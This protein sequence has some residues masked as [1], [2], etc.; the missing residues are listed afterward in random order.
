MAEPISI[1]I[2]GAGLAGLATGISLALET[3]DRPVD[4]RPKITILEAL[5]SLAPVGAGLQLTPNATR[6][7]ARWG[8]LQKIEA[9]C[10][11]PRRLVVHR[12][13]DGEVLACDERFSERVRGRYDGNPFIDVHRGDLQGLL[14]ERAKGLGVGVEWAERVKEMDFDRTEASGV[15]VLA[16]SGR[17]FEADLLVGAD[18]IW[19]RCREAL[20]MQSDPPL[21][22]GDLA[23]R[24]VLTT[25]ALGEDEELRRWVQRP[26]CHFWI[27][28]NSHVVG[29]SVRGGDMFN[30]VLLCPDDLPSD[31]AR[32]RGETSEM[33]KLFEGWDPILSRFLDKVTKVDKWKLMHRP[34]MERWVSEGGTLALIGDSCHPM[35]PYLAQGA[36]SAM[37]DGAVLGWCV[38][39][40]KSKVDLRRAVSLY[41][42]VRKERGERVAQETFLQRHQFHMPDGPEQE[43]RDRIFASQLDKDDI[44]DT[45]QFPSRWTCGIAQRWLYGYDA[46]AAAKEASQAA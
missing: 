26:E 36:N 5:P 38:G 2:V 45:I 35:L 27:G 29:Y 42:R 24:I 17:V 7:L 19:S 25:D 37:E 11:E 15:R 10:A 34:A 14:Y 43:E 31:V 12:Y 22:T 4:H 41:E 3:Q 21:P 40:V 32:Q 16:E 9:V 13:A 20:L 44:D 33:K 18:G 28:P 30:L 1:L 8:L 6:L 46:Y 39:Q 23:Y